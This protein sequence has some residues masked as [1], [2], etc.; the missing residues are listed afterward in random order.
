VRRSAL[1]AAALVFGCGRPSPQNGELG[2]A[3]RTTDGVLAAKNLDTLIAARTSA[4]ARDARWAP[5]RA[6]LVDLL[7]TRAQVFG[8]P[9]DYDTAEDVADAALKAAPTLPE[10]WLAVASNFIALHRFS[11]GLRALDEAAHRGAE[12]DA[13]EALRASA[14]LAQGRA[15]EALALRQHAVHRWA[16]T[17][18]LTALA[19]A[20][21][22]V[23]D[24]ASAE[25]HLDAAVRSYHDV[26]P[27]PLVFVDFQ[28]A[29]IAEERGDLGR[30][31]ARY[32]AAL[33]RLP[34]HVQSAVHLAT[35][36]LLRGHTSAAAAVLLSF[37]S[38]DDPEVI[39]LRAQVAEAQG[40]KPLAE[41][42]RQQTDALY[43]RLVQRHP[44]AYADHA[45][46]FL[47]TRDGPR[48]LAL[49][50][51]NLANRRT[52]PAYELALSAA[53]GAGDAALLCQLATDARQLP[54]QTA[55]L[56][57]LATTGALAC[58]SPPPAVA[59]P[60]RKA[61]SGLSGG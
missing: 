44:A 32:R 30:A 17:S 38:L 41:T 6:V 51:L 25:G 50:Q 24:W 14:Y 52:P 20:E 36:E 1:L 7:Q 45:A 5:E 60:Q 8:R 43:R 31:V 34:N 49:A 42:L 29:L 22:G 40:Q 10:S 61:S 19:V 9:G 13:V 54:Y 39:A 18:N 28:R 12:A 55:R 3:V 56:K 57:A 26:A 47:L 48:A 23:G 16:S 46:R 11:E 53:H 21:M 37:S 2:D 4:I 33:R 59:A 58:P 15:S 27:F 35:L